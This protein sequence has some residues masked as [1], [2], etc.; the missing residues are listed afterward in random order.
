[1][2]KKFPKIKNKA[3]YVISHFLLSPD[4][5]EYDLNPYDLLILITIARYLDMPKN[6]CFLKWQTFSRE[7]GGI[8][9][10]QIFKSLK[11]LTDYKLIYKTYRGQKPYYWLGEYFSCDKVNVSLSHESTQW[12]H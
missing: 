12:T 3:W 5:H 6:E 11:K 2:E 1:M 10:S 9:R 8:G 4:R 7:T